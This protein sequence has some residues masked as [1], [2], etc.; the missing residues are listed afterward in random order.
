M[1]ITLAQYSE[2]LDTLVDKGIQRTTVDVLNE[3]RPR[4]LDAARRLVPRRRGFLSA[5]LRADVVQEGSK[6]SLS[7]SAGTVY[8]GTQE[9]GGTIFARG[10]ELAVGLRPDEIRTGMFVLTSKDG[11]RFLAR[12][13]GRDTVLLARL[14]PAV[15]LRGF[16]YLRDSLDQRDLETSMSKAMSKALQGLQ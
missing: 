7:R 12:K 1:S 4:T 10:R 13:D 5:S 2:R 3:A 8:G 6:V 9:A 14:M 15:S 16:H 11:R